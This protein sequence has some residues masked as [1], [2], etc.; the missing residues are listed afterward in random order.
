MSNL[1]EKEKVLTDFLNFTYEMH[2]CPWYLDGKKHS[3]NWCNWACSILNFMIPITEKMKTN[4]SNNEKKM[5]FIHQCL[6]NQIIFNSIYKKYF[7]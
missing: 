2:R 3:P 4:I 6:S 5:F 1:L 7:W